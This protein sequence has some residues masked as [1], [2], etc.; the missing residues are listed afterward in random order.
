[1]GDV[2]AAIALG[3][4]LALIAWFFPERGFRGRTVGVWRGPPRI[5]RAV[6]RR[7]QGDVLVSLVVI[8]VWGWAL[9]L[10]GIAILAGRMPAGMHAVDVLAIVS[11]A[12][13]VCAG[14]AIVVIATLDRWDRR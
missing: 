7:G 4:S 1:M 14:S 3:L 2:W 9:V 11:I 10:A 6:L 13:L 5:A 8:Q 12:G